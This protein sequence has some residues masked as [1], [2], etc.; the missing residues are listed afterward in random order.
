MI[1]VFYAEK[2]CITKM[3]PPGYSHLGYI[4]AFIKQTLRCFIFIFINN[5]TGTLVN[6]KDPK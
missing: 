4:N 5:V 1:W 3:H 2:K 6:C